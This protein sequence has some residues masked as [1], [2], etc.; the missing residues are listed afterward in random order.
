[1]DRMERRAAIA[2]Y[3]ERKTPAGIYAVRCTTT[4]ECWVGSTPNLEA[5]EN[6]MRFT[7][8]Q[9][10]NLNRRM[11]AAW[12]EEGEAAFTFERVETLDEE[13]TGRDRDRALKES[14]ALWAEELDAAPA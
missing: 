4:G 10:I 2:A 7:L 9:G 12:K 13:L 6:R 1:M 5:I 14:L 8:G 11:Q 3:K